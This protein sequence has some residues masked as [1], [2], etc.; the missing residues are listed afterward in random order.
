MRD[1]LSH[2]H[3]AYARRLSLVGVIALAT[4]TGG[5]FVSWP[6][7]LLVTVENE[8]GDAGLVVGITNV[9]VG[10]WFANLPAVV[11]GEVTQRIWSREGDIFEFTATLDDIH[12][13]GKR[14][15]MVSSTGVE[16]GAL[17]VGVRLQ[18]N[19]TMPQELEVI[20]DCKSGWEELP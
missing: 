2:S 17:Q 1:C 16:V 18:P 4:A 7:S 20:F 11:G 19:P 3:T 10:T 15:C 12:L 5:C 8:L 14:R 9:T 6:D 13:P